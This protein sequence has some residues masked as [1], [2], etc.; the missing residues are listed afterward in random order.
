MK[1]QTPDIVEDLHWILPARELGLNPWFFAGG[2]LLAL[3]ILGLLFWLLRRRKKTGS[4]FT[5]PTPHEKAMKA[6]RALASAMNEDNDLEF[7]VRVSLIVRDYIQERFGLRAPHRSTEEFLNEARTSNLL[8]AEHQELLRAFLVQCDL[9]K[10]AKQ[11][12]VIAQMKD[13]HHAAR[14]FVEGTIPVPETRK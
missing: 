13:L 12:A 10:F 8:A 5:P 3:L 11:R 9:V 14:R 6:L 4:I 7:I 1:E 2:A